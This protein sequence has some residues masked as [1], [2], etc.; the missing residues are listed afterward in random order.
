MI[1]GSR[2]AWTWPG[3]AAKLR[4]WFR[5]NSFENRWHQATGHKK[6]W[7][8]NMSVRVLDMTCVGLTVIVRS[9]LAIYTKLWNWVYEFQIDSGRFRWSVLSYARF[10]QVF[11]SS[12]GVLLKL[13]LVN[14]PDSYPILTISDQIWKIP[15][16]RFVQIWWSFARWWRYALPI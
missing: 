4:N 16:P 10:C 9:W 11:L 8:V 6:S 15:P 3:S 13:I 1:E 14:S 2:S 5:N 12:A 7:V